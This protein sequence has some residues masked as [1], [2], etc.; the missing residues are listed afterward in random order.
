MPIKRPVPPG[1]VSPARPQPRPLFSA[2][3]LPACRPHTCGYGPTMPSSHTCPAARLELCASS[4]A[5]PPPPNIALP[6]SYPLPLLSPFPYLLLSERRP[7]AI[8]IG[9]EFMI[10]GPAS[11]PFAPP[12]DGRSAH[13]RVGEQS[14]YLHPQGEGRGSCLAGM[15]RGGRVGLRARSMF[16]YLGIHKCAAS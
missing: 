10:L 9:S 3:F 1:C 15:A 4:L 8:L 12:I 2:I 7:P 14:V 13:S 6:S 11:F 16:H 5:L